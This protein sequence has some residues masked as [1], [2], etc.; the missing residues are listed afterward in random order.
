MFG[1][2]IGIEN[3]YRSPYVDDIA[4][5]KIL[6]TS[7]GAA[8]K[9]MMEYQY[10]YPNAIDMINAHGLSSLWEGIPDSGDVTLQ[11]IKYPGMPTSPVIFESTDRTERLRAR[12]KRRYKKNFET[13]SNEQIQKIIEEV[14]P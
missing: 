5:L 12:Q 8:L 11:D 4:E 3:A 7:G 1:R 10:D 6:K 9:E 2:L 13:L 14:G